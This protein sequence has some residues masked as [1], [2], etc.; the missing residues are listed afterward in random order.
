MQIL[1]EVLGNLDA[2]PGLAAAASAGRVER[3]TLDV[4][5]AQKARLRT[6]TDGGTEIGLDLPRGTLLRSGDVLLSDAERTIVVVVSDREVLAVRLLPAPA[7]ERVA[8]ALQLGHLLGNQHWP[9]RLVGDTAFVPVLIDRE[10]MATVLETHALA[11][12]EWAFAPAPPDLALPLVFPD[13]ESAH[14]GEAR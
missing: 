4:W 12:L 7:Q 5:E 2:D 10:V 13:H 11:G 6:A 3:I 8:T 14:A 9:V 1:R